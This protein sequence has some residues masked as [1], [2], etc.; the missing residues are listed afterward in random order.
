MTVWVGAIVRVVISESWE[1]DE[2]R[3]RRR[4]ITIASGAPTAFPDNVGQ[5]KLLPGQSFALVVTT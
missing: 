5:L 3:T 4:D 2:C 1:A